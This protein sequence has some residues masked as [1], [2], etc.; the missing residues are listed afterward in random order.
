MDFNA[1]DERRARVWRRSGGQPGP[2]EQGRDPD[3]EQTQRLEAP[4]PGGDEGEGGQAAARRA[5]AETMP[6]QRG[7]WP[8]GPGAEGSGFEGAQPEG[9]G[10]AGSGAGDAG[11]GAPQF[12]GSPFEGP[13]FPQ[14][15]FGGDGQGGRRVSR[16][17]LFAAGGLA[18]VGGCGVAV[19][20]KLSSSGSSSAAA[21]PVGTGSPRASPAAALTAHSP[22][23]RASATPGDLSSSTGTASPPPDVANPGAGVD[24]SKVQTAPEYYVH[25]GA[26]VIALTLDDGPHPVYTPQ[27]LALLQQYKITATFCMIGQQVGANRSLVAEVV[28]AGHTVVNHTWNHADQSK[29]TLAQIRSQISRTSDA[30]AAAG[31]HPSVFRAPYG[32]WSHTVFEACAAADLRPLAWSVDPRDWSRPGASTIVS[33]ILTTTRT[34]SII[35]D[36]DG[37]G[38]RSQTVA[39]LKVVLPKLLNEGYRFT[40]V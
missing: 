30:L 17:V 10:S 28:A 9:A 31:A 13:G 40:T 5:L 22:S 26:K 11:F 2:G 20:S 7:A 36:H 38:D 6:V 21:S 39:A 32:A 14:P 25:A 37:G 24:A 12:D 19:A 33:R 34:G 18:L 23:A 4:G 3:L 1:R 8:D 35:L 16:R 29:L 27:V 15:G